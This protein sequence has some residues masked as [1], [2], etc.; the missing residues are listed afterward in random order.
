MS[1]L[2]E[3]F[4][5]HRER[6]FNAR[7]VVLW[8]IGLSVYIAWRYGGLTALGDMAGLGQASPDLLVIWYGGGPERFVWEALLYVVPYC[9]TLALYSFTTG[10]VDFWRKAEFWI[11][12]AI[13]LSVVIGCHSFT[14]VYRDYLVPLLPLEVQYYVLKLSF[15]LFVSTVYFFP[16]VMYWLATRR[17][18]NERLY[19]FSSS[20]AWKPYAILLLLVTPAV[21][22]ASAGDAFLVTYPRYKPWLSGAEAYWAVP[23][24]LTQGF[25]QVTYMLQFVTLE[26]FFRGFVVLALARTAGIGG[27]YAM[28]TLYC[29]IH[30]GKPMMECVSSIFGGYILGVITYHT[31]SIYGGIVVHI[32]I[33][34]LMEIAAS[35]QILVFGRGGR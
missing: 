4:Q 12:S 15:N 18:Y 7:F 11:V 3:V 33:A 20:F 8:L 32:G 21:V 1:K 31:R 6:E 26:F 27:V 34:A 16:A 23:V 2:L 30:F 25:Y 14:F 5:T 9:A 35:V 17:R 24:W 13:S 29:I 28:T 19:G 10:R 22:V